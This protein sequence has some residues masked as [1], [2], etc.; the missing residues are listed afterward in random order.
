MVLWHK[1]GGKPAGVPQG[2]HGIF[3]AAHSP[4]PRG[5]HSPSTGTESQRRALAQFT[6]SPHTGS[7]AG[8][9][10]AWQGCLKEG[11]LLLR[12][13]AKRL[14]AFEARWI[15]L[16]GVNLTYAPSKTARALDEV[17]MA[18]VVGL[19][20]SDAPGGAEDAGKGTHLL[21]RKSCAG[22]DADYHRA[23]GYR[24]GQVPAFPLSFLVDVSDKLRQVA[25]FPAK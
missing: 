7:R 1:G 5:S 9:R 3:L 4:A 11:M 23:Q 13:G 16:S 25:D 12:Q 2:I 14:D 18:E 21:W 15:T 8:V 6:R 20:V 17:P 24:I 19:A 10:G 22:L